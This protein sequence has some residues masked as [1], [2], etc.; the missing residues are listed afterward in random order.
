MN[1]LPHGE[2]I[3]SYMRILQEVGQ[4]LAKTTGTEKTQILLGIVRDLSD[5]FPRVESTPR[6][7]DGEPVGE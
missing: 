4:L 1:I 2:I 3:K 6:V 7:Y 5:A